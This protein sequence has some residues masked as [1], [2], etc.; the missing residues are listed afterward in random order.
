MATTY[1]RNPQTNEFE[2]VGPGGATTDPTLSFAGKPADAAAVGN[3]LTNYATTVALS[4]KVDKID[5]QGLSTNDYTTAEKTKLAGIAAGANNY[6]AYLTWG[7][8]S[9]SGQVSPVDAAAANALSANRF[10]FIDPEGVTIEYSTDGGA[11]ADYGLTD[12]KKV[13]LLSDIGASTYTGARSSGNTA[14]DKLRITLN[15]GNMGV[16]TRLRKLLINVTTNYSTGANVIIEKAL[17]SDLTTFTEIGTYSLSGNSGWNSIPVSCN[18]GSYSSN[19]GVLRLTFGITDINEAQTK[20]ALIVWNILAIGDTYWTTPSNMARTGHIYAYDYAQN[21][22][23]PAKITAPTFSGNLTGTATKATQDSSGNIII[24]TYATKTEL[25]SKS[26]TDHTHSLADFGFQY[27]K[28]AVDCTANTVSTADVTF[29]REYK[30]MPIV[31][32]TAGT[33][34]PGTVVQEVSVSNITYTGFTVNVYRTNTSATTVQW[35]A[36]GTPK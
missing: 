6:E 14:N 35:M 23:F 29:D 25:D 26:D 11:W 5:G 33:S 15:A 30:T 18:F 8:K 10:Q 31:T 3:A 34:V 1:V 13:C 22:T 4:E 19:V 12:E 7:G 24:N 36:A 21:V 16:Y 20:N 9:L 2:L 28:I 17:N 32:V 27:G